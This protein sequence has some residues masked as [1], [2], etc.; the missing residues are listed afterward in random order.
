MSFT[1]S[2]VPKATVAEFASRWWRARPVGLRQ[3]FALVPVTAALHDDIVELADLKASGPPAPA[4][5]NT[6]CDALADAPSTWGVR[7]LGAA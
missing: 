6:T 1:P 7:I 4:K 2:S 3:D 5:V